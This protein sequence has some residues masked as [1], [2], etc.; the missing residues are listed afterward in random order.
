VLGQTRDGKDIG[1][2][3]P[4]GKGRGARS[5]GGPLLCGDPDHQ[6]P[7]SGGRA[8]RSRGAVKV[9]P[10]NVRSAMKKGRGG[11]SVGKCQGDHGRGFRLG[12]FPGEAAHRLGAVR[13][14]APSRTKARSWLQKVPR[15]ASDGN[16]AR[17]LASPARLEATGARRKGKKRMGKKPRQQERHY[18]VRPGV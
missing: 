1:L 11:L 7:G 6:P 5:V 3:S 12:P 16:S 4:K 2:S 18:K 15:L 8:T 10:R 9:P 14:T 13:F 17:E